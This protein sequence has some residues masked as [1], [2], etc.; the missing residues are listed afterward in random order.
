D[1]TSSN[2]LQTLVLRASSTS[3]SNNQFTNVTTP[4]P[5]SVLAGEAASSTLV[6]TFEQ[7]LKRLLEQRIRQDRDYPEVK[8]RMPN[9]KRY[10]DGDK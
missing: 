1:L 5:E 2:L 3:S 10:L 8:N 4:T 6:N 9:T 7:E